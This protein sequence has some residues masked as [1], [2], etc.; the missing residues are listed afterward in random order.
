[1]SNPAAASFSTIARP[2]RFAPPVTNATRRLPVGSAMMAA[3]VAAGGGARQRVAG[4]G[5]RAVKQNPEISV[6]S[7]PRVM[8]CCRP[9]AHLHIA[10]ERRKGREHFHDGRT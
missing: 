3:Y 9:P 6:V 1:M 7:R 2:T 10:G 4:V 5:F 8:H